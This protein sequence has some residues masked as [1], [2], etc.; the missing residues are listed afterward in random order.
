MTGTSGAPALWLGAAGAEPITQLA[1]M[2]NRHGL[3]AGATGT[4]KTVTLQVLAEELS[5]LG[6]PVFTA[7][8][9]GDLS[10]LATA[11]QAHPRIAE[12]ATAIGSPH[13]GF[14]SYPVAFWDVFG[15]SGV[16]ART[17][18]SDVGPLLLSR[19]LELNATQTA[20]LY[21]AFKIADDD[22]LLLLDLPDLRSLLAW[23]GEHAGELKLEYGN[24]APASL[25]AIQRGLLVLEQQGAQAMFGEPALAIRDLMQTAPDGRGIINIL[26]ATRLV[27]E[28]PQLY[29]CFLVWLLSELFEELPER[30]D[31][32][33][34]LFVLFF[35]EA[36]LL[37][38]D[39]PKALV[40]KIEQVVRLIR[41][42][43]IG[44]FFVTQSPLDLPA[45]VLGQ[46]GLK[47]QHA[48]RA[49]TPRDQ[50]TVKVVAESFRP[51]PA[52][53]T[54][55][56][57]TQLATGEA[58]VSTLDAKGQP[59]PVARTLIRPPHSRIGPLDFAERQAQATP[60]GARYARTIDRESAHETLARRAEARAAQAAEPTPW[61]PRADQRQGG[62]RR[63]T[64]TT[65]A[66]VKSIARAVGSQIGSQIGRQ[67]VR[68]ILGSLFGRR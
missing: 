57:L 8:V 35:D 2:M 60:Q 12:R 45:T 41:S 15:A 61:D 5:E 44:V 52:L 7:D 39:A 51:N 37:F 49:F 66:M 13:F 65:E 34:P 25:A 40:D 4:G 20:V 31:A 18:I 58:L 55:A 3:V 43:G 27:A 67:I 54:A 56:V 21:A 63:Q 16:P 11:G 38:K 14:A 50:K 9:K 22:G 30:G 24:L 53:D 23:I 36:H 1:R 32:D 47:I 62:S 26:D 28:S 64:T 17:T 48:L 46:L 33:R 6:I 42:K 59:T 29:A 19:L 68:G 10:G